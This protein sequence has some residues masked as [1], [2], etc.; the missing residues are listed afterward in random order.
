M[1]VWL[2]FLFYSTFVQADALDDADA[3]CDRYE[4]MEEFLNDPKAVEDYYNAKS[5]FYQREEFTRVQYDALIENVRSL[6]QKVPEIGQ[7]YWKKAAPGD[8]GPSFQITSTVE[9]TGRR[10]SFRAWQSYIQRQIQQRRS[11]AGATATLTEYELYDELAKAN[12]SYQN[13]FRDLQA[14]ISNW[15]RKAQTMAVSEF[16]RKSQADKANLSL[17]N[18]LTDEVLRESGLADVADADVAISQLRQIRSNL[19]GILSKFGD[20]PAPVLSAVEDLLPNPDTLLKSRMFPH[21]TFKRR[22]GKTFEQGIG[23]KAS[24]DFA[25]PKRLFHTLDRGILTF[26]CIGGGCD[27]K[28]EFHPERTTPERY[29]ATTLKDSKF[30]YVRKDGKFAGWVEVI[31]GELDGKVY[32]GVGFGFSELKT[33]VVTKD[34]DGVDR[35]KTLFQAWFSKM[36]TAKPQGWE[37]LVVSDSNAMVNSGGIYAARASPEYIFAEDVLKGR[38]NLNHIDP[39]AKKIIEASPRGNEII[40]RYAGN[41][42]GE[43]FIRSRGQLR[44]LRPYNLNRLS[45]PEELQNLLSRASYSEAEDILDYLIDHRDKYQNLYDVC[46]R[47]YLRINSTALNSDGALHKGKIAGKLVQLFPQQVVK[48]TVVIGQAMEGWYTHNFIEEIA[49]LPSRTLTPEFRKI[50]LKKIMQ[51]EHLSE[52]DFNV[53]FKLDPKL[54]RPETLKITRR[55]IFQDMSTPSVMGDGF[56]TYKSLRASS[57]PN[58]RK[59]LD[60]IHEEYPFLK[61]YSQEWGVAK[62][63]ASVLEFFRREPD[64][65]LARVVTRTGY[66]S[67]LELEEVLD[68]ILKGKPNN[69]A[70]LQAL[71]LKTLILKIQDKTSS[72]IKREAELVTLIERYLASQ[73]QITPKTVQQLGYALGVE[74]FQLEKSFVSHS[75]PILSLMNHSDPEVRRQAHRMQARAL[76]YDFPDFD[77]FEFARDVFLAGDYDDGAFI[78]FRTRERDPKPLI[79][80]LLSGDSVDPKTANKF[81]KSYVERRLP[82]PDDLREVFSYGRRFI[83]SDLDGWRK[84]SKTLPRALRGPVV[85]ELKYLKGQTAMPKR[86]P[87]LKSSGCSTLSVFMRAFINE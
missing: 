55:K 33:P 69:G 75:E 26:E 82:D 59:V 40:D 12:S 56:E 70:W 13:A 49:E 65:L 1:I 41:M 38:H 6:I 86:V 50:F 53:L 5:A 66:S 16:Q 44:L 77:R 42:V 4:T 10:M 11:R 57:E 17:A 48:D 9:T 25:P 67:A 81:L 58:A 15:G 37:G 28:R 46:R 54:Q 8:L 79:K 72:T 85:Q 19:R 78:D 71:T 64:K 2:V 3:I 43:G 20:V 21:N 7:R 51:E 32:G 52:I 45:N 74:N 35:S 68:T 84:Y 76:S 22:D 36:D 23:K 27:D 34:A 61:D 24:Y 31:P 47:Y 18:R 63:K 30:Q 62:F 83:A 39:L 87:T 73:P 60:A 29:A 14:Q 80:I